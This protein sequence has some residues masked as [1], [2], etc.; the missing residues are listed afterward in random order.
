MSRVYL[1]VGDVLLAHE[2][3]LRHGGGR[4]GLRD[5]GA[6]ESAVFRPQCG[7]FPDLIEEAAAL[8][9]SLTMNHPFAD[10]NKHTAFLAADLYLNLNGLVISVSAAEGERFFL[11]NIAAGTF[12]LITIVAWL[13]KHTKP[14]E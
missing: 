10:A 11:E 9:E 4:P 13:H 7:Y 2:E 1:S 14:F 6:L 12:T 3:A 5:R 8:M